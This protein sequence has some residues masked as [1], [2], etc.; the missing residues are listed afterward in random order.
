M[1]FKLLPLLFGAYLSCAGLGSLSLAAFGEPVDALVDETVVKAVKEVRGGAGGLPAYAIRSK[2]AY[3]FEACAKSAAGAEPGCLT[4]EGSDTLIASASSPVQA[5]DRGYAVPVVYLSFAPRVNAL[6]QPMHLVVYG[7]LELILGLGIMAFE[8]K[9]LLR[10][11]RERLA[12]LAAPV[13]APAAP[14]DPFHE[15]GKPLPLESVARPAPD[16]DVQPS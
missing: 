16:D 5:R 4:A 10:E 6:H 1:I 7:L 15:L 8:A 9:V 11:R 13:P 12:A 3:H 2:V 14:A